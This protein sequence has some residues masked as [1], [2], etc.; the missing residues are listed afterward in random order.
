MATLTDAQQ[1]YA[2]WVVEG[3]PFLSFNHAAGTFDVSDDIDDPEWEQIRLLYKAVR[4]LRFNPPS[5]PLRA[6]RLGDLVTGYFDRCLEHYAYERLN[7]KTP[8]A[9]TCWVRLA[10]KT[11]CLGK[12]DP[13]A[14]FDDEAKTR[15]MK[16]LGRERRDDFIAM[17]IYRGYRR[18]PEVRADL[19]KDDDGW[20]MFFLG[21]IPILPLERG[22]RLKVRAKNLLK[23]VLGY[24]GNDRVLKLARSIEAHG[25]DQELARN[26]SGVLGFSRSLQRYFVITG[27][28]R[29]AALKYLHSQGKIDGATEIEYPVITYPWGTWMRG[30]PYPGASLCEWCR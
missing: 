4:K 30:R 8:H 15:F 20:I 21:D 10:D 9:E 2:E 3:I 24:Q 19:K 22:I 1:D 6:V 13:D 25:W 29:I 18:N 27:R 16:S 12:I 26:P 5:P 17:S 11:Y 14:E 23:K 7:L 28:H